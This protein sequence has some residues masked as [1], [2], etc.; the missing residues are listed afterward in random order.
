MVLRK[1]G[2]FRRRGGLRKRRVM[3]KRVM[4]RNTNFVG[5]PNTAKVTETYNLGN[6]TAQTPYLFIKAGITQGS[7]VTGKQL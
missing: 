3:R 7:I 1:R 2:G 5:G 4:K 6:I